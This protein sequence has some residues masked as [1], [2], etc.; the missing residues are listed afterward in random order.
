MLS[1]KKGRIFVTDEMKKQEK[2]ERGIKE[3]GR[4]IES[5]KQEEEREIMI[6]EKEMT[7]RN[8]KQERRKSTG[9]G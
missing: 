3:K 8:K 1:Y 7:D 2:R 4:S 9:T 6:R 5:R